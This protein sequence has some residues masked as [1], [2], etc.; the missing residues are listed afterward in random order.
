MAYAP[1]DREHAVHRVA[2]R[3]PG[4]AL[5]EPLDHTGHVVA[6]RQLHRPRHASG[7]MTASHLRRLDGIAPKALTRTLRAWNA[8]AC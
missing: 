7:A 1:A 4:Q 3:E 5:A 2:R 8:R 6:R